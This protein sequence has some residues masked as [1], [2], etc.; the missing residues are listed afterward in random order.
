MNDETNDIVEE[1]I[2]DEENLS[3]SE[4]DEIID[5]E[6][7]KP[8]FS[9]SE[10]EVEAL[11]KGM[12]ASRDDEDEDTWKPYVNEPDKVYEFDMRYYTRIIRGRMPTFEIIA[13]RMAMDLRKKIYYITRRTTEIGVVGINVVQYHDYLRN[14]FLPT[15]LNLYKH[16]ALEVPI[17]FTLDPKLVFTVTDYMFGGLGKFAFRIMGRE[18]TTIENEVIDILLKD[19]SAT[20][21]NEWNSVIDMESEI[22]FIKREVNPQF[23]NIV[24]PTEAV[25]VMEFSI[26]LEGVGGEMHIILPY[27]SLT[28]YREKLEKWL[29]YDSNVDK[30]WNDVVVDIVDDVETELVAE[31][32]KMVI[33]HD[34][35]KEFMND[36]IILPF[37]HNDI[38]VKSEGLTLFR[39]ELQNE[40]GMNNSIKLNTINKLKV[41]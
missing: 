36:G 2:D 27:N 1:D 17:L 29:P 9:L 21:I 39:G 28:Q 11:L 6:T 25:V 30:R 41:K 5:D 19:I 31:T 35:L 12:D 34:E 14:L 38:S 26:D 3:N 40:E 13:E 22:K 20:Y 7:G 16:D 18:F 37:N 8:V 33:S 23:A 32:N 15:S 4:I 24:G 10:E